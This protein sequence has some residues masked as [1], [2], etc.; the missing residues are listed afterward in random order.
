MPAAAPLL[1][2]GDATL[3]E[4]D[5]GTTVATFDVTLSSASTQT[6]TVD[7]G[8]ADGT[9][10]AGADYQTSGGTLAFA[11]GQTVQSITVP[12]SG[13]ALVELDETF[14]VNLSGAQNAT[15][16]DPQGLG[17]ITNDDLASLSIDN[18]T[19]AEGDAGTT[20]FDF[21]VTLDS[22]VDAPL[23]VRY[24]TADG[25]ATTADGDYASA[26]GTLNF[27]GK[28]GEQQTVTVLVN[29]DSVV[30][31][32]ESF[33]VNLTNLSAGGRSVTIADGQGIGTITND[34]A[35][36]LPTLSIRGVSLAEG[37]SGITNARFDVV[38]SA[39]SSDTVTVNFATADGT[40]LAGEDYQSTTGTL[41]FAPGQTIESI[42]VPIVGD[43]SVEKDED[44]FVNLSGAQNA[45]LLDPQ[46]VGTIV[47]DDTATSAV[48]LN[49]LKDNTLIENATGATSNGAGDIYVG[50]NGNGDLARRGLVAFDIAGSVP[51]GATIQSVALTMYVVQT[52]VGDY[53]VELHRVLADWGEAGSTGNGTGA[54]AQSGDATWLHTFYDSELWT[55][56]GGDFS[57]TA[58]GIATVGAQDAFYTWDASPQMVADVQNWLDNPATNYGWLLQSDET[59]N[60]AKRFASREAADPALQPALLIQYTEAPPAEVSI[61]DV[62]LAE[63]DSGSVAARFDVTL[64]APSATEVTV[65][66]ATADGSAVAG[67]D[68][69]AAAGTVTFAPGETSQT[70]TVDVQGDRLVE[71]QEDF[72][73]NLSNPTNASIADNQGQGTITNDDRAGLAITDVTMAEGNS[74][75][76][77]FTFDVTLDAAVDVP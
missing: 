12:V 70:I 7:Y 37:N 76:T 5:A 69:R 36:P 58:S 73:V 4:G 8:T 72:F 45:T 44:F 61:G 42:S 52:Q 22:A 1:S 55:N 38:L 26:S 64:S 65:D 66:F 77:L 47:N 57:P 68:Y 24:A 39:A 16:Q 71:L 46:A 14:S 23:S 30:E 9:A 6:V 34:D 15:I 27:A 41:T 31:N 60:S 51:A 50:Q 17:T 67:T 63:G 2:I 59:Q 3:A 25:S 35:S 13:D 29:G 74:G 20:R 49:P 18:V 19:L 28:A 48:T 33:L 11:P 40:A 32:D 75:T 53:P 43:I 54:Q 10:V 21:T 62:V 56:A